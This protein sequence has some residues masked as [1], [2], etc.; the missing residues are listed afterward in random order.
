MR[1]QCCSMS[2]KIKTLGICALLAGAL[3]VF[4]GYEAKAEWEKMEKEGISVPAQITSAKINR[5]SKGKK[6]H[7]L[8]VTWKSESATHAD[9][10]FLVK[11]EFFESKV[12]G[13]NVVKAPDVTVK[14][15]KGSEADAIIVGGSTDFGGME[16]L[17][18]IVGLVG[19]YI[20]WK[21]FRPRPAPPVVG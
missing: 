17:G 12:Q 19:V 16:W 5:T 4:L 11:K 7:Y 21:A 9:Q 2:V 8:Y 18:Y 20:T 10:H 15:V 13:E 3:F 14:Y 6:R 1:P